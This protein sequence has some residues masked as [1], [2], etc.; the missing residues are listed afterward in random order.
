ML[1]ACPSALNYADSQPALRT[2]PTSGPA[3]DPAFDPTMNPTI[4]SLFSR[5]RP[6]CQSHRVESWRW[7]RYRGRQHW[8]TAASLVCTGVASAQPASRHQLRATSAARQ[9]GPIQQLRSV[10]L[11]KQHGLVRRATVGP[12]GRAPSG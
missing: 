2:R 7:G 3:L 5:V 11:G 9:P 12:W 4:L 6:G 8:K 1:T 10:E